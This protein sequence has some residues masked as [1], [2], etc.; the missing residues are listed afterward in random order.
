MFIAVSNNPNANYYAKYYADQLALMSGTSASS[1]G[2]SK[3]S[4][5]QTNS[6]KT[7]NLNAA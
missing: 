7:S 3:T 1:H 6:G 4:G 5:T 2:N